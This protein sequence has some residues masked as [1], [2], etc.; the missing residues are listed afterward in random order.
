MPPTKIK[1]HWQCII[2]NKK[3]LLFLIKKPKKVASLAYATCIKK[4]HTIRFLM[5][6]HASRN[7]HFLYKIPF[8]DFLL[9]GSQ[10]FPT[11]KKI[12]SLEIGLKCIISDYN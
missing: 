12:I 4:T 11:L 2:Y 3:I 9:E 8:L 1:S 6:L 10:E 7:I 5:L